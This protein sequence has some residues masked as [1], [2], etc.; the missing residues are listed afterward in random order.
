MKKIIV[1][2][3]LSCYALF[4]FA[5]IQVQVEPSQVALGDVFKLIITDD[6]AQ[7]GGVPDLTVLQKD[8]TIY[9]TERHVNY[10][11]ING[12]A[13]TASQWIISLKALKPGIL[14][15]P[16][17]KLG[18]DKSNP[19]TIN[20]DGSQTNQDFQNNSAQ[21][22][23]VVLTADVNEKKPYVNQQIIYTVKLYNSKRLL[24]AEY[25]G[26]QVDNAL[27][28]PLGDAKRYQTVQNNVNYVVEEQNYAIF[29]Q[30][31]GT[32][33]IISPKFTAL[34]YDINSQRIKVEDKTIK[35]NV[36]PIPSQYKGTLWLPAKQVK[37]S[38]QY[39]NSSQTLGQGSTLTRTVTLE[40]VSIPAQLL[41]TLDFEETDAFSVYPEK[42][43]DK[44]Q[45]KQGE[46]VGSTQFKVTY[47]FN[48]AGKITIP[49]LRLHWFNTETGKD[50]VA[51]LA[52]R[53]LD[54]TPSLATSNEK[55][56]S[57]NSSVM[58]TTEN[59]GREIDS[60]PHASFNWGWIVAILF[61]FAW[62]ITLGLWGWQKHNRHSSKKQVRKAF[63]EL[64]KACTECNPKKARD[65]LLKW[66][67]VQ[68]PDAP[69]LNL[70]DLTKLVRDAQLKKQIHLLS[71]VLYKSDEKILWRGDE[72]LRAVIA[73]KRSNADKKQSSNVLP[74]I[75]PF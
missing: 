21:Q 34:I 1:S 69:L 67:K 12:Q 36:Q 43:A 61:A 64:N 22:Q 3:L 20:V 27:L 10:I 58:P 71:Q 70:S 30:K 23:D 33:D 54:I 53:S 16:A 49:E 14:T 56:E 5:E 32:L 19:I 4:A 73:L 47:L 74:P 26:P 15:I 28:I 52:P 46:L 72:L 40:G 65:A 68:W 18:L 9:G 25:Q 75:N 62:V 57:Q 66:G 50:E 31:S 45:V 42:G 51:V 55:T 24:D 63:T 6:S 35:L 29:P 44:N 2:V 59:Q 39:E 13:Q 11:L 7:N 38:E 17:I 41:P 37:L 60:Y 8:F 48:K